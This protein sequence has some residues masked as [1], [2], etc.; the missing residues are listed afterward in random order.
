VDKV[1]VGVAPP[2]L[3]RRACLKNPVAL[4]HRRVVNNRRASLER[5]H[6]IMFRARDGE[7]EEALGVLLEVLPVAI[8][9]IIIVMHGVV[10]EPDRSVPTMPLV[11]I[12]NSVPSK[13]GS[14]MKMT[15]KRTRFGRQ[16]MSA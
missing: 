8:I 16:S 3:V 11:D 9:I 10:L 15:T 14:T 4:L 7:P 13:K 5:L 6:K 12:R 1:R 2:T